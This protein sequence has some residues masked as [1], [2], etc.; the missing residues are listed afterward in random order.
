[1][2]A[3]QFREPKLTADELL[4]NDVATKQMVDLLTLLS[5]GRRYTTLS[6]SDRQMLLAKGF[7]N[8]LVENVVFYTERPNDLGDG[9]LDD[10][11]VIGFTHAAFDS[12]LYA[13]ESIMDSLRESHRGRCA[14]CESAIEHTGLGRVS[15]FRPPWGVFEKG[16]WQRDSYVTLAYHQENLLYSCQSCRDSYKGSRFPVSDLRA[17]EVDVKDEAGLF[18]NPYLDKPRDYIRFNPINS[19]AF[20]FDKVSDFI[21][22]RFAIKQEQ[23]AEYLW[24]HPDMIPVD[25]RTSDLSKVPTVQAEF[26]EWERSACVKHKAYRGELT[27]EGFGL[28]RVSL[29]VARRKSM[30]NLYSRYCMFDSGQNKHDRVLFEGLL[31]SE[32]ALTFDA[33]T[34]DYPSCSI[35][36]YN[37][38]KRAEGRGVKYWNKRY[39]AVVPACA[40]SQLSSIG[41][42]M[43]SSLQYM[44]LESELTLK[45]KRRIVCLHDSD[46]LYGSDRKMKTVFLPIDWERDFDN[47]IKVASANIVWQTSVSELAKTQPVAL[48]SLFANNEVWAE[49][50]YRALA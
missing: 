13:C 47:V 9:Q 2:L 4:K 44:V 23:V 35:D 28:N 21:T 33:I 37:C 48:Q 6:V 45:G 32:K 38:W 11:L 18:V 7:A 46:F 43:T 8:D 22:T 5:D 34:L 24:E 40:N 20:P 30:L 3:I 17:P 29:L 27:I 1:M 49:G 42:W 15:H 39:R 12:S 10:R 19:Q 41:P 16:N 14:Y 26:V 36:A 31:N 50:D 25:M